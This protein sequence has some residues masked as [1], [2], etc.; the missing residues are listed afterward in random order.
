MV[1]TEQ[2]IR[3]IETVDTQ[4]FPAYMLGHL[5]EYFPVSCQYMDEK[6]L[7]SIITAGSEKAL[8]YGFTTRYEVC[9]FIDIMMMVGTSFDTDLQ[10]PFVRKIL[11]LPIAINPHQKIEQLLDNTYDYL[12][13]VIG[14]TEIFPV[15]QYEQLL[16][17]PIQN[18][19]PSDAPLLE[20]AMLEMLRNFWP[21]KY[22]YTGEGILKQLI[23]QGSKLAG[24][25]GFTN[26]VSVAYFLL[27][28]FVLG[29][30]FY[31]DPAYIGIGEVLKNKD[32]LNEYEQY[33]Q[34][35]EKVR[36]RIAAFVV[37]TDD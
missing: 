23:L 20:N 1:I 25:F 4:I 37:T 16:D 34:L 33:R 3:Q 29:H 22:L 14:E 11:K 13:E 21:A 30:Q 12:E 36:E 5:R 31:N 19:A 15:I 18:L 26:R 27:L 32:I 7:I 9:L 28:Q 6:A 10:L 17:E 2:Q 24:S 8:H 35:T